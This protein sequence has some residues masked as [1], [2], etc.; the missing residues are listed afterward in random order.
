[1]TQSFLVSRLVVC[2]R[3][4]KGTLRFFENV[5]QSG[6]VTTAVWA[7]GGSSSDSIRPYRDLVRQFRSQSVEIGRRRRYDGGWV[8]VRTRGGEEEEAR[9]AWGEG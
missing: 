9:R 8:D 5:S 6:G 7:F 2:T 3:A 4:A 1:M